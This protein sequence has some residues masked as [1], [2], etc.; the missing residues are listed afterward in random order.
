MIDQRPDAIVEHFAVG[1]LPQHVT[2]SWDLQDAVGR[3]TTTATASRRSTRA[4]A[5]RA[6]RSRSPTRTTCTSPPTAA[7]DRR[8]RG[9]PGSST[10]ATRTRCGCATRSRVPQC[11][12]VDHMDFTADGRP[13]WSSCEF[14]GRHDRRRPRPRARGQ[15]DRAARRRD[16]AGREALARRADVLRRRHGDQR[17]LADRRADAARDPLPA[18]RARRAR[19]V[20][21]PRR[22]AAVR[23]QP[24]RGLDQRAVVP[25]RAVRSR[26]GAFPA[27]A[28]R[29][30][31]ASRPTAACCG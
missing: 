29:T 21:E 27:A 6:G 8:R 2:P 11:P 25:T 17:R 15:D 31:A 18:D 22:A 26:S 12:G 1:A 7:R 9:A 19:P 20:P 10:S 13:R 4:P 14:A 24:R 5:A 30:W 23:L 3:P 16:A 28:R